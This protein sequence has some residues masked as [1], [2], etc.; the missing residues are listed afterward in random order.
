MNEYIVNIPQ[1][2]NNRLFGV[3][4]AGI[5]YEDCNY[6]IIRQKNE[7]YTIEYVISGTGYIEK[8]EKKYIVHGGDTYILTPG[9]KVRYYSD[10]VNPWRKIWINATGELLGEAMKTFSVPD[11]TVFCGLNTMRFFERIIEVCENKDISPEEIRLRCAEIC[12]G[13]LM[14]IGES[15][16]GKDKIDSDAAIIKDYIDMHT[17]EKLNI[18]NIAALIYKSESQTIRIFKKNFGVTPY[19][20]HLDNKIKR[21]KSLLLNTNLS[22]KE[23]AYRLG[24]SDEHYFSGIFKK[25]TGKSPTEIRK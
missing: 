5:T 24:F 3:E 17:E 20:Y 8:E 1:G 7:I 21:A 2:L 16:G 13:M 18:C 9:T 11:I 23:T 4:L 25:K 22:V 15:I 12:M 19:D 6:E 14:Y 10:A